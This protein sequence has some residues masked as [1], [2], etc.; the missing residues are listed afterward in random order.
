MHVYDERNSLTFNVVAAP[1]DQCFLFNRVIQ[2]AGQD[3]L[4]VF[5][6][7]ARHLLDLAMG[8]NGLKKLE[9]S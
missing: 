3:V 5:P 7:I 8:F 2:H 4:Q 1:Q 6:G 9:S